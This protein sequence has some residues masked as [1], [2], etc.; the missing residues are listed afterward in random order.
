M[1]HDQLI[2]VI[3][4]SRG[5]PEQLKSCIQTVLSLSTCP[6]LVE[7]IIY[8][9]N[10]DSSY[11]E[12]LLDFENTQVIRGPRDGIG[13]ANQS[14]VNLAKGEI[15]L[16]INDDMIVET[17]NWDEHFRAV[18]TSIKDG[19]YLAYP[20]D[21]FKGKSLCAFH[22]IRKTT[23]ELLGETLPLYRGAFIDTHLQEVFT[24]IEKSHQQR[25]IY[26]EHVVFRHMHYRVT[27]DKPDTTYTERD[28]FG[29]DNNFLRYAKWRRLQSQNLINIIE[30]KTPS[31]ITE[32]IAITPLKGLLSYFCATHL[33]FSYRMKYIFY[34]ISRKIYS[35]FL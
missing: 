25:L 5:R 16:F 22:A 26:L 21:G 35:F 7:F 23:F 17:L 27:H 30:Y 18:D 11:N 12:I 19:I 6:A 13:H 4:P 14:C 31:I 34:M 28:R 29:D 33:P 32:P 10:D 2:S 24:A 1:K 20:N 15:L 3:L 8:I 9:D